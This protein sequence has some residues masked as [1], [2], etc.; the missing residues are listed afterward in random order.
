MKWQDKFYPC[1]A[2]TSTVNQKVDV[3]LS[4]YV[5]LQIDNGFPPT[6]LY[7]ILMINNYNAPFIKHMKY[8]ILTT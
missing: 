6:Y 7:M 5:N 2:A 8:P 3:S 1:N 4:R